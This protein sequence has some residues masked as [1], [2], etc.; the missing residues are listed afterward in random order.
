V[1][2]SKGKKVRRA[3]IVCGDLAEDAG[4]VAAGSH[5]IEKIIG[6]HGCQRGEAQWVT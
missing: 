5:E 4:H 3:T 2:V 1:G 6:E